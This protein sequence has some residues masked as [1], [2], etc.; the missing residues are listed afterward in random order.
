MT[1]RGAM[2]QVTDFERLRLLFRRTSSLPQLP[3]TA[4]RLINQIDTGEASAKDLEKVIIGDPGL[5]A[6]FLRAAAAANTPERD[7][8]ISSIRQAILHMGQRSV[9]SL[10]MSLALQGLLASSHLPP[11]FDRKRFAYHSIFVGFLSRYVFARRLMTDPFESAWSADEMFAAG[12]LHDLGIGLLPRVAPDVFNR[13]CNYAKRAGLT[14]NDAFEKIFG[15]H[16]SELSSA[17]AETW[18]LPDVFTMTL[19]YRSQPWNMMEEYTAL[20]CVE[21]SNYIAEKVGYS[22][23]N[24]PIIIQTQPEIELE[25]ALPDEELA[26]VV[27]LISRMTEAHLPRNLLA[28]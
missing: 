7:I 11:S 8:G 22:V 19:R 9:R 26:T 20:C 14:L 4:M 13:V 18:G 10:A 24:W 1:C 21:Y 25:V 17:A 3:G 16:I 6:S 15:N 27:E 2:E 12:V 28:A 23:A 5:A